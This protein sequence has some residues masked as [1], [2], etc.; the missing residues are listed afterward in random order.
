MERGAPSEASADDGDAAP[1]PT[2]PTV[3]SRAP[4]ERKPRTSKP[5]RVGLSIQSKLLI[6]LLGVSLISSIIV[7][8][9]GFV[10]GR[11]S[12]RAAAVDQ[13][14]TI[15]ELRT[16]E[17]ERVFGGVQTGVTLDSRNLS[18]QNASVALNAAFAEAQ[19]RPLD[20][21]QRAE[22]EAY[23]DD[24]FNAALSARAGGTYAAGAFIPESVAGQY[25][26]YQYTSKSYR[27][28]GGE[29]DFEA[30]IDAGDAGDGSPWSAA[31]ERYHD[32][33]QRI[34]AASG[35]DDVLLLDTEG[36]VVYTAY[37][38][39]DLGMNIMTGPFKDSQLA[40]AYRDVMA[41]NSVNALATTDYERY[42]P[43]LNVPA[44]WVVS[45]VGNTER[46]T[47]ALA[48]QI[49]IDIIN[50]V[51][52]GD[53]RWKEQGLGD[54]GEVYVA[55]SDDLM[56]SNSRLLIEDP[57]AFE[58]LAVANGTPSE[59]AEREVEVGGTVLLQPVT[60]ESVRLAQQG[61]SGTTISRGYLGRENITAYTPVDIDGL[62]WVAVAR[63]D[64]EEAFAPVT[65]F[66]RNLVIS[67][68]AILLA[69]SVLSMLLAQVFT[70]PVR[71]LSE[72]VRRV[73]GGDLTVQVPAGSRDEFG[74]LGNAFNDMSSSLRIKQELIDEQRM[75]NE[76]LLHTLMPE[77][78]AKRYQDG[79]ETIS[80]VHQDV[81]V[82]FA[83]LIGF[84][85]FTASLSSEDE[86]AQLNSLMR[87]FDE[88]AERTG[89]EKVRTL[90]G[91][92]LASSG[93]IVPRVDNV[94]RAVEF[95]TELR[96][97]IER[98]NAGND[99]S[100]ELRAGIATGTV[101]S[102]LVGRT[103]LAYDLWGDAVNLAYRVRSVD[104]RPGIYVSQAVKDRLQDGV[105]IVSAGTIETADGSETVWRVE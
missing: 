38:G 70:R 8:V 57:Q 47:G 98:F 85:D 31:R 100:V 83:E 104:G 64:T 48:V 20:E 63:I 46:V 17:L 45:P 51:L 99:A 77:T 50:D 35:Y 65:D 94:R 43:S 44:I 39:P 97:V 49:P 7:G 89:V 84:D 86:L 37:S 16:G 33:F 9:I 96:A 71:H 13:L 21:A 66:T 88:A 53:E 24:E 11:E 55:G 56:R 14:T 41:T 22:L 27:F 78:V 23:Y 101:T 73:A 26:Q 18:A 61:K 105:R 58:K 40:D 42:I 74:D 90:R 54:T 6:M 103:S 59:L 67:T 91:G 25:L 72:A 80:E 29:L 79:E 52:T 4:R 92:Y 36:N 68:L 62:N 95:A 5:R 12:L 69:V 1:P 60:T 28:P 82:I 102:G 32:Y 34:I 76:R 19:S 2:A 30:A 93:L 81:S 10:S 87:G 3:P 15:R 75:E